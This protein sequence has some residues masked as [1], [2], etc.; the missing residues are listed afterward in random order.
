MGRPKAVLVLS[1]EQ[2]AQLES[3]ASSR[4]LPAGLVTRVRIVLLS[5]AGKMNQQIARQLGLTNATVGKWRR[6]FVEQGVAGLHDELRPGRPRPNIRLSGPLPQIRS[7]PKSSDYVNV[8]PGQDTSLEQGSLPGQASESAVGNPTFEKHETWI[9]GSSSAG[10]DSR[11]LHPD[12][13]ARDEL[14]AGY[15]A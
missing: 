14:L 5:A 8:F 15:P 13:A 12:P 9:P 6:R 3:M 7:L 4:S 1:A 2:R 11:S 10:T